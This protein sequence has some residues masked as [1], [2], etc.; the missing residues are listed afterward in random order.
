MKHTPNILSAVLVLI[1]G[2]EA[3]A[4]SPPL[5]DGFV[6]LEQVAPSIVQ[7][8]RYATAYNFTGAPVPGYEAGRCI[9]SKPAAE[10]LAGVQASLVE[11]GLTLKVYDCYR[12]QQA[13]NAFVAW[14][15]ADDT[16]TQGIFYPALT[17]EVLFPEGYIARRSGHSRG[18]T[19]DLAIAFQATARDVDRSGHPCD[20][21]KGPAKPAG[22]LDFGTAYDCFDTLS[23][24]FDARIQGVAAANRALLVESMQPHGFENYPKEWWHFTY[25]PEPFPDLY[26]DF[27]VR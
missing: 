26:F 7:D 11:Q 14:S 22:Q 15:E 16:A 2:C 18:S 20:Q 25:H 12:P 21:A 4:A 17:K 5:P 27:P 13:V 1:A 9:L 3:P 6:Y 19:V 23:H 24:T 10:A 8:M